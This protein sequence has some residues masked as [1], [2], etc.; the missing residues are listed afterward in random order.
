M[1]ILGNRWASALIGASFRGITRFTDFEKALGA[2]PTLVADRIRA[3]AAMG[4][5]VATQN[6]KRPDRVEYHLTEKG[7][8]FLPVIVL[9]LQWGHRWFHAPEGPALVQVHRTC[10][11]PFEPKLRCDQCTE[12]LDSGDIRVA[13]VVT[14]PRRSP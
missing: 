5:L 11:S 12:V 6:D 4:V 14:D 8:A 13:P 2:P 1:K 9:A 10:G 7:R 3:F